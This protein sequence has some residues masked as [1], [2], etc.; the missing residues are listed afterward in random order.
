[1]TSAFRR[2]AAVS[3]R[4]LVRRDDGIRDERHG[5]PIRDLNQ[6]TIAFAKEVE[7][8]AARWEQTL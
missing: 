7:Q 2:I 4:R 5:G 6:A 1:M 8:I 3:S